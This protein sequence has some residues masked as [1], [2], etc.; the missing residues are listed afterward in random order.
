MN[1]GRYDRL[2]V[3]PLARETALILVRYING[4]DRDTAREALRTLTQVSYIADVA[5]ALALEFFRA[6]PPPPGVLVQRVSWKKIGVLTEHD[7]VVDAL[8]NT[9]VA[10]SFSGDAEGVLISVRQPLERGEPA[11]VTA[12]LMVLADAVRCVQAR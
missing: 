11:T 6:S 8:A 1:Y 3:P 10:Y 4:A 5:V 12:A 7:E 9:I 2:T